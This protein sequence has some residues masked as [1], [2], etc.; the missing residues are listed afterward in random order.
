M[1]GLLAEVGHIS[2]SLNCSHRRNEWRRAAGADVREQLLPGK[3]RSAR[4][5]TDSLHNLPARG[6]NAREALVSAP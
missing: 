1:A 3:L 4:G 6:R 5:Q 2:R